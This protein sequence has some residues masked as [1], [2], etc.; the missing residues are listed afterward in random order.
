MLKIKAMNQ[1]EL[2][3]EI[4]T[5]DANQQEEL[6]NYIRVLKK[7]PKINGHT[8][9]K[10]GHSAKRRVNDLNNFRLHPEDYALRME[11]ILELQDL[12]KDEPS[13]E[14]LCAMLTK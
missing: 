10:N 7:K 13:A 5:L 14:E 9:T 1:K 6:A 4:G 2:L 8:P 12:F 11:T 3:S